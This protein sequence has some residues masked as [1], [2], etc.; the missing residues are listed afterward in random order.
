ML[1]EPILNSI[2]RIEQPSS[3]SA[4]TKKG[5]LNMGDF[6]AFDQLKV[7]RVMYDLL[8][9]VNPMTSMITPMAHVIYKICLENICPGLGSRSNFSS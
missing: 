1:N 6:S 7:I 4:Y 8:E 5:P 3:V 9:N 2:L